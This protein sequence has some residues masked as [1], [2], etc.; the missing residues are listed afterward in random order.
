MGRQC[1]K[2]SGSWKKLE[3]KEF[4]FSVLVLFLIP[5][6]ASVPGFANIQNLILFQIRRGWKCWKEQAFVEYQACIRHWAGPFDKMAGNLICAGSPTVIIIP[7]LLKRKLNCKNFVGCPK[8]RRWKGA[9][10]KFWFMSACLKFLI[11]L[12]HLLPAVTGF[13]PTLCLFYCP[14]AWFETS[15]TILNN[16]NSSQCYL[17]LILKWLHY[18]PDGGMVMFKKVSSIP[19]LCGI[20]ISNCC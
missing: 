4:D 14:S 13:S 2:F 3:W 10:L 9:K 17:F 20:F 18:F 15:K 6:D 1:W 5:E 16:S 12:W 19:L 7:I 11:F 8:F